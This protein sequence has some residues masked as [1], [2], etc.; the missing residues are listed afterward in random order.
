[1]NAETEKELQFL[2]ESNLCHPEDREDYA[3]LKTENWT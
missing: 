1:M 2:S 3:I